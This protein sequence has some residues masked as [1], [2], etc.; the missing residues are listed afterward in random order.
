MMG[1]MCGV[2]GSL[3]PGRTFYLSSGTPAPK[4]YDIGLCDPLYGAGMYRSNEALEELLEK[5]DCECDIWRCKLREGKHVFRG[6]CGDDNAWCGRDEKEVC[7]WN[8]A[9]SIESCKKSAWWDY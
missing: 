1:S 7:R 8:G 6:F 4:V 2:G 5:H 9:D 3:N